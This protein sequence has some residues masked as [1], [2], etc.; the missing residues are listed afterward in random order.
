LS[1][2]NGFERFVRFVVRCELKCAVIP[3]V[4]SNKRGRS[5]SPPVAVRMVVAA[6][7]KTL[8]ITW[9]GIVKL[10]HFPRAGKKSIVTGQ[11]WI[12]LFEKIRD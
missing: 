11:I 7:A 12:L 5:V 10:E 8:P 9:W 3:H 6:S 4:S 1:N 2:T